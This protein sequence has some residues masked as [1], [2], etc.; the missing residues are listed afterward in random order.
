MLADRVNA[1]ARRVPTGVIYLVGLV[2]LALLIFDAMNNGLGPNPVR[3]LELRLGELGL[4]FVVG[5]LFFSP[6][7]W[8]FGINLVKFRRA[9]GLLAF[10]YVSLHL[11]TWAVL[12]LGLRWSEI[13][14]ELYKRPYIIVGMIGFLA[15]VPLAVTSNNISVRKLGAGVWTQ[16]HKLTYVAAL[17]GA[18][19]YMMLVKAWPLE[20]MLYLGAVVMLL[21]WRIVRSRL[22]AAQ[23]TE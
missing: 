14:K 18:L 4:K 13:G 12:D 15:M 6:L 7:R 8:L 16:L 9:I 5:G 2:P 22:R 20:P 23:R 10:A 3:E 19:H 17:A 11:V 21:I 1:A